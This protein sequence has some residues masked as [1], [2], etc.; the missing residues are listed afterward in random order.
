MVGE[1][2][3]VYVN[4]NCIAFPTPK[5]LDIIARDPVCRRRNCSAFPEGVTRKAGGRNASSQ[6]HFFNF[7]NEILPAERA[8]GAR[9]EWVGGIAR[10]FDKKTPKCRTGHSGEE[11]DAAR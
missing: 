10:E 7:I 1:I 3:F 6:E 5:K 2:D 8:E 4:V 9:K 11:G